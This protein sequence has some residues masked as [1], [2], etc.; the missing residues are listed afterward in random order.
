MEAYKTEFH[1]LPHHG[2]HAD[3][4]IAAAF[5]GIPG[6]DKKSKKDTKDSKADKKADKEHH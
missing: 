2:I 6:L 1:K 4:S 3:T 5:P